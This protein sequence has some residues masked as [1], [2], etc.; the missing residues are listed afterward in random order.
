MLKEIFEAPKVVEDTIRGRINPL[1]GQVKLGGLEGVLPKLVG[2]DSLQI[3]GC[4]SAF[5]A[6]LVGKYMLK[7]YAN[8]PVEVELGSEYRYSKQIF[9][10]KT[11]LLAI[12]QSGETA[13]TLASLRLAKEQNV[14]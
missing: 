10:D 8:L 2:L 6:G 7:E 5:Y 4:G 1:T 11:A 3:V 12:T 9:K 14:L 13:D